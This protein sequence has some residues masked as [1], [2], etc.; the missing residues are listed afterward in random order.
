MPTLPNLTN[1]DPNDAIENGPAIINSNFAELCGYATESIAGLTQ[2][3]SNAQVL[4][5]TN[6]QLY[7]APNGLSERLSATDALLPNT[8]DI[9]D[10]GSASERYKNI[11]LSDTAFIGSGSISISGGFLVINGAVQTDVSGDFVN[12]FDNQSISGI[13]SF[14]DPTAFGD[15]ITISGSNK[16]AIFIPTTSAECGI[17]FFNPDTADIVGSLIYDKGDNALRLNTNNI[18]TFLEVNTDIIV[19]Q[20]NNKQSNYLS[21]STLTANKLLRFR[22][23]V[24]KRPPLSAG[25]SSR[26]DWDTVGPFESNLDVTNAANTILAL[27]TA[28]YNL[29]TIAVSGYSSSVSPIAG[30]TMT[31]QNM[32]TSG[33]MTINASSDLE[34]EMIADPVLGEVSSISNNEQFSSITLRAIYAKEYA[35]DTVLSGSRKANWVIVSQTGTWA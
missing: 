13:K 17:T 32:A 22:D 2:K 16:T 7:I 11:H 35:N 10:I 31:F 29:P 21:G 34:A 28:D 12:L 15:N 6:S 5:G 1:I 25:L 24:I 3:A 4:S 26:I 8:D 18:D 33:T 23:N 19:G 9:H 14:T 20:G 27:K 30:S